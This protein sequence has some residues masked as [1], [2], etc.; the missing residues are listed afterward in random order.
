MNK[1]VERK[2]RLNRK[3]VRELRLT[4]DNADAGAGAAY[5]LEACGAGARDTAKGVVGVLGESSTV[6]SVLAAAAATGRHLDNRRMSELRTCWEACPQGSTLHRGQK[7]LCR[8]LLRG[9]YHHG[10]F[11]SS[12]RTE[13]LVLCS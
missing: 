10:R 8:C 3:R 6:C 5:A 1:K 12:A 4:A 2:P 13:R 9:S 11:A 7:C